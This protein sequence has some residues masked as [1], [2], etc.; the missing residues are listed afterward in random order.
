VHLRINEITSLQMFVYITALQIVFNIL[1]NPLLCR[2][3]KYNVVVLLTCINIVFFATF[4]SCVCWSHIRTGYKN[5][6]A[7]SDV[8]MA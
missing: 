8:L 2:L 5:I 7:Q 6:V 3:E 4:H 1:M